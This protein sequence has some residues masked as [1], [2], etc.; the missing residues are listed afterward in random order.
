[1]VNCGIVG[2]VPST[3]CGQTGRRLQ[4]ADPRPFHGVGTALPGSQNDHSADDQAEADANEDSD[5][6]PDFDI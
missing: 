4:A 5:D 2:D 3:E 1:M 6:L